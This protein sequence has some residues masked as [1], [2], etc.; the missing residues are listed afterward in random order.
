[1]LDEDQPYKTH[2][3]LLKVQLLLRDLSYVLAKALWLAQRQEAKAAG[4]VRS[5]GG[6]DMLARQG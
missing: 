1:M 6:I 2:P 4:W 3:I 5:R